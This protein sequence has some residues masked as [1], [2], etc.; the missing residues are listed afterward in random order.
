MHGG[1][2]FIRWNGEL[3]NLPAQVT[4][5]IA[6]DENLEE[7]KPLLHEYAYNFKINVSEILKD[8]FYKLTPN[9]KNPYKQLYTEN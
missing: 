6:S 2:I 5:E 7:I 1:S 3:K 9:A 4:A 8:K